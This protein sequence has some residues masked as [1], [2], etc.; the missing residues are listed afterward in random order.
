VEDDSAE[1]VD[2]I[3][4]VTGFDTSFIPAWS[5]VGHADHRLDVD[6][7]DAPK[8]YA[9]TCAA[10]YPNYFIATGPGTPI[11]GGPFLHIM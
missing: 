3:V 1:D 5:S 8:P 7:D 11:T 4:C 6:W 10:N 2:L 9:G